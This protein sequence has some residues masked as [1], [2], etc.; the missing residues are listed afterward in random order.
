MK[1]SPSLLLLAVLCLCPGSPVPAA[2]PLLEW[3]SRGVGGGGALFSPSFSPHDA[4]ELWISC[5]MSELFQTKS[6]GASWRM[7]HFRELQGNRESCAQFTS[8]PQVLFAVDYT[9]ENPHPSR[10]ADGGVTWTP[11][12]ND[13]TGGEAYGTWAD[14]GSTQRLIVNSYGTIYFSNNAGSSWS[15]AHSVGSGGNGLR[16]AGVF[17]DSPNIFI[18]TNVGV[19][20]STNDGGSFAVA[21]LTG[22]PA[23]SNIV[24]FAGGKSGGTRRLACA[25]VADSVSNGQMVEDFFGYTPG[26]YTL[27]WG[28]STVWTL[29]TNGIP[30]GHQVPWVGMAAND[31]SVIWAAGADGSESP[32]VYRSTNGGVNWSGRLTTVNN[33]NVATGWAGHGGDRGWTYGGNPVGFSV[34]VNDAAKAAFTDY[35][36]CHVTTDGGTAWRQAYV[37]SADQN[38]A[39]SATPM[40]KSYHSVGL[41]DTTC[42]QVLFPTAAR[43]ILCNSD[44]RASKSDDGGVSWNFDYTGHTDNSMYRVVKHANGTLYAATSSV[45]DLYQSTYLQDSRIDGGTG[46]VLVSTDNGSTWTT[47]RN[48]GKVV[49]WVAT[50][51]TNANRLYASVVHW[52]NGSSPQ[53]GIWRTDNLSAGASATWT[54]CAAPPRTEGHPYNIV[55]LN[56]GSVVASYSARRTSAGAFTASSGVFMSTNQGGSWTDRSHADMQYWTKDVVVDPHDATQNTWYACVFNGWGGAPNDKGGLLRSMNRGQN[57]TRVFS[58]ND[59]P[60]EIANVESI[61]LHPNTAGTAWMTTENDGLWFTSDLGALSPTWEE[62]TSHPFRQPTRVFFDPADASKIWVT[63]FGHGLSVGLSPL[64][65]LEAWR[66]QHFGDDSDDDE[67]AGDDEDPDG[68]GLKNLVEFAQNTNP[69]NATNPSLAPGGNGG[70]PLFVKSG[71]TMRY[72]YLRRK[73]STNPGVT[74]AAESSEDMEAWTPLVGVPQVTSVDALWERVSWLVTPDEPA[75]FCRVRVERE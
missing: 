1:A 9:G 67:I 73:A 15:T 74:Y 18:G 53:G 59:V 50:D 68:D 39:G 24:S 35:G 41:E 75:W 55:V 62:V 45:H 34:A 42:W 2:P 47:L 4:N 12:A 58:N 23:G 46:K 20:V 27:D 49:C 21:S 48:F 7:V 70:T 33:G 14:P 71:G 64:T 52:N 36:F 10:S 38:P 63:S 30:S 19:V 28:S 43:M 26:I 32:V 69:L 44:I 6:L 22:I 13:P 8:D 5:D 11:L 16:I 17:W 29:R 72:E 40:G 3:H 25:V 51:P 66:V 61:T 65:P 56:D 31:A 37:N 54:H 60:S 57:W